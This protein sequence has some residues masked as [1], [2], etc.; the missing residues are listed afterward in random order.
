MEFALSNKLFLAALSALGYALATLAM[1]A[2]SDNI[3]SP[4]LVGLV[5]VLAA[6]VVAEIALLRQMNL[7]LAYIAIIAT[8][9]IIILG[10]AFYIGEGLSLKQLVGGAFIFLG[11]AIVSL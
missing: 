3:T 11:V 4:V 9:T 7:G 2:S 5:L 6:A 1:K 10:F 8:E